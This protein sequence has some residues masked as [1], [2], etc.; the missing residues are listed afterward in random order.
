[1][2]APS[3]ITDLI[4]VY[5]MDGTTAGV[6]LTG[7]LQGG[8]VS[9]EEADFFIQGEFCY[10]APNNRKTGLQSIAVPVTT[11]TMAVGE[12][13]FMWQ[14]ELAG[15]AMETF[16]L[17]GLRVALCTDISNYDV[18]Y[19]G[20][21]DFGRNPYGG[22]QNV[23]IDPTV[24]ADDSNG[25]LTT[26]DMVASCINMAVQIDKG[27]LHGL[28]AVRKGRGEIRITDGD[29]GNGYGTFDGIAQYNDL[30]TVGNYNS[31]GLFQSEGT[32]Y[33]WKG[34]LNFGYTTSCDFRDANRNITIDNT[35]KTYSSFNKII[36][37]GISSNVEWTAVN[38]TALNSSQ[39]SKGDFEVIDTTSVT[40]NTCIF[41]DMNTF[42]FISDNKIIDSTFRRC[43]LVTQNGA[44]F[45]GCTF[46][47][48]TGGTS[49]LVN[50]L[51]LISA[52]DFTSDGSNHAMELDSNAAENTYTL[53]NFT[54][55]GY[56][57]ESGSTGNEV[58]YN[59]SG[60]AVILSKSG[61][62]TPTWRNGS[63]ASTTFT[64]SITISLTVQ[65]S[66][67][68][69]MADAYVYLMDWSGVTIENTI[70]DSNGEA[71]LVYTE[72]AETG[73]L[74]IRKYGYEAYSSTVDLTSDASLNITMVTDTVQ[75]ASP[76]DLSSTW[77]IDYTGKT[78][79]NSDSGIGNNLPITYGDN[80]YVNST[81]DLFR[82]LAN[83][84]ASGDTMQYEYPVNALT[85][86]VYENLNGWVFKNFNNDYKYLNGGSL[87][88][89]DTNFLWAN[90]YSLGTQPVGSKLYIIQNDEELSPWWITGNLDIL[91]LV[92]SGGTFIQSKDSNGD[93][94]NGS[95][96]VHC[97]EFGNNFDHNFIEMPSGGRNPI[98][99]NTSN[100]INNVSG[101]IYISVVDSTNFAA[102]NFIV[103]GTSGTVSKIEKISSNDIYLNSVRGGAFTTETITEYS[104]RELQTTTGESTTI[105]SIT[106]VMTNFNGITT[107]FGSTTKDLDNGAGL[108]PYEVV[109]DC[110]G[111]TLINT[112]QFLKF[113]VR[114][115]SIDS[116]YTVQSDDGQEYR[117]ASGYTWTDTKIAPFGTF[118]GGKFF[119]ARG[120]WIENMAGGDITNYQ[121]LDSN[122]IS[123]SP[124]VQYSFELT[125]LQTDSEV[126]IYSG[127][128]YDQEI[129][130]VEDSID[131]FSYNYTYVG[132]IDVKVIIH[133][134]D[135]VYISFLSTLSNSSSS[136]PIQQQEDRW[137]NNPI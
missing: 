86:T 116:T 122:N 9:E 42:L 117:N 21:E 59:N 131:T 68:V 45:D 39:V 75:T 94:K 54:Y 79:G 98:A 118:A 125:E 37:N 36:F 32:G 72:F 135:Y 2:A 53:T 109:V 7:Y 84:F 51:D 130:G 129:A 69:V 97:R 74:R 34:L 120:V 11:F 71:S 65:D 110:S 35:P 80:T 73:T 99:I 28:D 89:S 3:Y 95:L 24:T 132:D 14:V 15:N 40:L 20:G 102:N 87:I 92:K 50:D 18:W 70:T 27:N 29:L 93:L 61:G 133:N 66:D 49:L 100:D 12:C 115:G 62:D 52:C 112:Y 119:G 113:I 81:N 108:R 46:D 22:W 33:L 67:Q 126:R 106:Q 16:A 30:N 114:Y 124:P 23:V 111:E 31:F 1:M 26:Y 107:T 44:T 41:T 5:D 88:T 8:S 19:T 4:T 85:P 77:N 43:S 78:I 103:G 76:P 128:S 90:L 137:Y 134:I 10:S 17:G 121:L 105:N 47:N 83:D 104:D 13:M 55:T 6:E 91:V 25:T 96:W 63:G 136:I 58:I 82:W 38:F 48:M 101:E 56:A 60:G 64:S 127:V 57:T 123:Q